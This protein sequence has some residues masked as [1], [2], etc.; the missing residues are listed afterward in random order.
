MWIERLIAESL[1]S[2]DLTHEVNVTRCCA[3]CVASVHTRTVVSQ[4]LYALPR[5]ESNYAVSIVH[6]PGR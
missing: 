5:N 6:P 2:L 1:N 4:G 3:Q